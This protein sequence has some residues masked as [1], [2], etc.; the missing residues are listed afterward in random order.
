MKKHIV[1]LGIS[2]LTLALALV[3]CTATPSATPT[4]SA[5]A[6]SSIGAADVMFATMMI[7]HHQQAV[8]MAD[9]IAG[10]VDV[11]PRVAALAERI[12]QAQGPEIERMQGWLSAWGVPSDTASGDM[13]GMHHGMSGMLSDDDLARLEAAPG[14]EAGRLFV[15]Q[16]I[17]HHEGAIEMAQTAL[18]A[19]QS[20]EVRELAQQVVDDQ[21][22]EIA[23]MRELLR[24]L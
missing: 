22:T 19:A 23:E 20:A 3:G 4:P 2:A 18:D 21:S 13:G 12:S 16:M 24:T 5:S 6:S 9:I 17:A 7:P 1:A 10:K 8:Q 11:D 15:E 14:A